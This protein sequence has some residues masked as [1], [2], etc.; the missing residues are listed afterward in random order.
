MVIHD[1]R[2]VEW[3][4]KQYPEGTLVCLGFMDEQG[5]PS[6]LKGRVNHVDDAGQIHVSWE[7]GRGLALIPG[8]DSFHKIGE[9][10][11]KKKEQGLQR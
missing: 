10:Q 4:R 8:V 5:M 3:L 7:N 2:K 6:G 9:M 11:S 1:E